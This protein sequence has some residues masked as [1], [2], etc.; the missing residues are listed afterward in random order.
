MCI[1]HKLLFL[2]FLIT[3][4]SCSEERHKENKEQKVKEIILLNN[5]P[6]ALAD[7]LANKAKFDSSNIILETILKHHSEKKEYEFAVDALNKLAYNYRKLGNY[8]TA[9]ILC[10]KADSISAAF[11]DS[12]NLHIA[13]TYYLLGLMNRDY[14]RID[15]AFSFFDKSLKIREA[16]LPNDDPLLGDIQNNIGVLYNIR[17]EIELALGHYLKALKLRKKRGE[18]DKSVSSTYMNIALTYQDIRKYKQAVAYLDTALTISKN[19]YG[20][21][22]P[23]SADILVNLASNQ[24]DLGQIDSAI[25]TNKKAVSILENIYGKNHPTIAAAYNNLSVIYLFVTDYLN[26]I[27]YAQKSIDIKLALNAEMS[28]EISDN[29]LNLGEAYLNLNKYDLAIKNF[30][31]AEKILKTFL[32]EDSY[33]A[34]KTYL[35]IAKTYSAKG[36]NKKA[37]KFAKK[38]L[39]LRIKKHGYKSFEVADVNWAIAEIYLATKMY[40]EAIQFAEKAIAVYKIETEEVHYKLAT[41]YLI[42]AISKFEKNKFEETIEYCNKAISGLIDTKNVDADN[43]Q[44]FEKGISSYVVQITELRGRAS[45]ELFNRTRET[46]LLENAKKDFLVSIELLEKARESFVIETSKF[47]FGALNKDVFVSGIKIASELFSLNSNKE[48]FLLALNISEKSRAFTLLEKLNETEAEINSRIPDLLL[49]KEKSLKTNIRYFSR[50][51][52][53]AENSKEYDSTQVNNY[54][55][56]LFTSRRELELLTNEFK[57]NYPAYNN[58]VYQKKSITLDDIRTE[59]L[60][61]EQT[62]VEYFIAE[63]VIYTFIISHNSFSLIEIPYSEAFDKTIQNLLDGI[64]EN[65]FEKYQKSAHAT[66]QVLFEPLTDFIFDERILIINDGILGYIPFDALLYAEAGEIK[67]YKKLPYL[68]NKYSFGYAFSLNVMRSSKDEINKI[69]NFLGIAPQLNNK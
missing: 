31:E 29:Y 69:N 25:I 21:N 24:Q 48:N 52:K 23:L 67:N 40:D 41:C 62:I 61:E 11:L 47:R 37:L 45:Y 36:K 57:Q 59:I 38:A 20:E 18:F 17:G 51:I 65:N 55:S 32:D 16:L 13:Q 34:T 2:V 3:L 60:D 8:N 58:L 63:K 53:D 6:F 33:E 66:Y 22:N 12:T 7:S 46:L 44:L 64:K 27:E 4:V 15:E 9:F 5:N 19:I 10:G 28:Y 56:N 49:Q 39:K 54:R 30:L 35:Y 68:I 43:P 14:G 50:L 42:I 1:N 26:A